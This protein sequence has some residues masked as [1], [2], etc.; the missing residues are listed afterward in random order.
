[1]NKNDCIRI[2]LNIGRRIPKNIL[3]KDQKKII[4]AVL[5]DRN[6]K[7][8]EGKDIIKVFIKK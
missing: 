5:K 6:I 7:A 2:L 4:F 3:T 8:Y 1:M